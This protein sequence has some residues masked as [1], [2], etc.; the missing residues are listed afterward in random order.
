MNGVTVRELEEGEPYRY[1]GQDEIIGY[2]GKL[3]KDRVRSEYFRRVKKIW[4]SELNARNKSTAQNTF[5]IPVLVPIIGILDWT[6]A[7]I[8]EIDKRTRKILCMTGNFHRNSD[9]DR[10]YVTR[11]EGGRGLKS[12]E[13]SYTSRMVSLRRHIENDK[14]NNHYLQNVEHNEKD[15]ILRIGEEFERLHLGEKAKDIDQGKKAGKYVKDN[16]KK[17]S[18]ESWLKKKQHGYLVKQ[19]TSSQ[20]IDTQLTNEWL[21]DGKFSSHNEGFLFAIQEQEIDTRGLRKSRERDM[22]IK[23]TMPSICRL[24]GKKEENIFHIIASCS[25]FSSNHYLHARHNP[26][27]KEVY[28]EFTTQTSGEEQNQKKSWEMPPAIL[29]VNGAEVW[30]DRQVTTLTKIPHNKPASSSG[31]V[32]TMNVRS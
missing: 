18:K 3:N 15:R 9:K 13:E 20:D 29:K 26:V 30:W 17:Q 16:I 23:A 5:A 4:T 8:E 31:M 27:A 14:I 6:L 2:D 24:C 21:K 19:A 1:L 12:F 25:Y 22:A 11:K 7:E 10:L 32:P 28:H